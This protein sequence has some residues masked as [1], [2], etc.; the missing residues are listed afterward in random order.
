MA[1]SGL[2]P[3]AECIYQR[4]KMT[5]LQKRYDALRDEK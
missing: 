3:E 5:N 4:K 2:Y 1:Q